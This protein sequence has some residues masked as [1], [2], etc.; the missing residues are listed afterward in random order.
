MS[1]SSRSGWRAS[2]IPAAYRALLPAFSLYLRSGRRRT[3]HT[4][5]KLTLS[6]T[7]RTHSQYHR[8][9]RQLQC[10]I[11]LRADTL[12]YPPHRPARPA[13][14][15][16]A[17]SRRLRHTVR[18]RRLR[19]HTQLHRRRIRKADGQ[20]TSGLVRARC[21]EIKAQSARH[22]EVEITV[23]FFPFPGLAQFA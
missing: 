15:T 13:L 18:R 2:V 5:R 10:R 21:S 20:G 16:M 22:E 8:S 17:S 7:A 11:H 12:W 14:R 23:Q 6:G 4:R 1:V 19:Q 3:V 9:G